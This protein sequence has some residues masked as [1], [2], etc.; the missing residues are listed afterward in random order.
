V[1][2]AATITKTPAEPIN[3]NQMIA[4][5]ATAIEIATIANKNLNPPHRNLLH[6]MITMMCIQLRDDVMP[7]KI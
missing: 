6:F 3:S 5:A 7:Y 4:A 1:A 2:S